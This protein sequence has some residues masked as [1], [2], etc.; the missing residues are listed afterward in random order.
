MAEQLRHRVII[1]EDEP[2]M[3]ALLARQLERAGYEVAACSNGRE[4][5][6]A[7]RRAGSGI[8]IADW[9]MPEMDGLELCRA[10][11][12]LRQAGTLGITY[13]ILLTAHADKSDIVQGLEAGADDY[14][15][16]PYHQQELLARLRA[17]E[18]NFELQD[19]LVQ[20][21][22]ELQEVNAE[23]AVLNA[24]LEK[25]ANTDALTGLASRRQVFERFADI[26][27]LSDRHDRPVACVM[28]D[29][30]HFKSVND[31]YGHAAGDTILKVVASIIAGHARRYDICGRVGGEEFIIVCPETTLGGAAA[32]ADRIRQAIAN[33][34]V[35]THGVSA[36]VTVSA[37][38]AVRHN[39]QSCPE[40]LIAQADGAL[41]R[42]KHTGR[43]QV[44]LVDPDGKQHPLAADA[45]VT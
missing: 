39:G 22:L 8:I 42:A 18:R 25:A 15:T 38:V 20:R 24:R 14:L 12:V 6:E 17:G 31:T 7:I 21:Q 23:M 4:A 26:W 13:F 5:L 27:A 32:L 11:K 35:A 9:M 34:P 37:G 41:Y 1:A 40:D 36:T 44:W 33:R 45:A 2:A 30:D 29:I 43:N 19:Q 10:V 28:F 3:R 16:K